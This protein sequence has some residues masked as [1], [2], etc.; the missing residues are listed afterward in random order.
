MA[1]STELA[2]QRMRRNQEKLKA[3][4]DRLHEEFG[5]DKLKEKSH[6]FDLG[7]S[8]YSTR[9][10]ARTRMLTPNTSSVSTD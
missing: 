2:I 8:P 7:K 9:K 5:S 6:S 10:R 3:K 4:L 1:S